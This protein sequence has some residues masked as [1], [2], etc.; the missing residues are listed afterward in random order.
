MLNFGPG[1]TPDSLAEE[2]AR[3]RTLGFGFV[4]ISDHIAV[5]Q[6]VHAVYP[7]PFYDQFTL[8]AWLAAKEPELTLGTTVTVLPYRHPLQ[9]ARLAANLDVLTGGRF[10]LGAGIGWSRAEY[11]ALNV[12]FAQR[13]RIADEYLTAIRAA[14]REDPTTFHGE[15]VH[16]T[17]VHTAPRPVAR[18]LPVWVGGSS[19]AALRRAARLGEGW[20]PVAPTL[21]EIRAALPVLA[22]E[23]DKAGRPA[24]ELVPRLPVRITD[25][26]LEES[27][28]TAGQGTLEQ[29][30]ADFAELAELG[31]THVL[32][33]TYPGDPTDRGTAEQDRAVLEQL[34]EHVVDPAKGTVR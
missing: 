8:A 29:I 26:P 5:T 12:P 9:T 10:I 23:A 4:M 22:A 20:H 14:W 3:A 32:V 34:T 24:P 30:R 2:A 18:P 28:R 21:D 6:D 31:A 27:G 1:T 13:G 16:Y 11:Q 25:G 15:Y 17:D 19:Q 7:A 33:D